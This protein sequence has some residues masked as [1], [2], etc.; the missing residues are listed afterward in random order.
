MISENRS[1]INSERI[2]IAIYGRNLEPEFKPHLEI[3]FNKLAQSNVEVVVYA[4]F[5]EVLTKNL[6]LNLSAKAVYRTAGEVKHLADF[7]L[8][9]GGDGTFLESV[10]FV[11]DSSIPVLGINFGRLGFLANISTEDIGTSIDMLLRGEYSI[12]KRSLLQVISEPNPYLA[13]PYGLNDFTI[14]KIG[15]AMVTVNTYIDNEFLCTY[16]SDGLIIATPTGSTAYSLS[17]GGP[18]VSPS[19]PSLLISPIAPHHLTVRPFVIPDTC[20]LKLEVTSRTGDVLTS[21]DSHSYSL[22][23]PITIEIKKAPFFINLVNL[24]GVNMFKTL[25]AKLLWGAD[26]RN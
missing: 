15:T 11:E 13:F 12:E 3:L 10:A 18:I 22:K 24:K 4:S 21:L 8:S 2:V 14:Q 5:F 23:L 7:M 6:N 25:R 1:L 9:L 16:W 17:V 19:L 26:K 20:I